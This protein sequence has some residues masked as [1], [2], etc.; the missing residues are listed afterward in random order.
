M[1]PMPDRV[2]ILSDT[3]LGRRRW[4][5]PAAAALRP[6]WQGMTHLVVNGDCA[7]VHHPL[8]RERAA[9]EVLRLHDLCRADG[10]ALVLLS[11]NHDPDLSALRHLRLAD[12]RV[13]VTHGDAIHRAVA[14]WS[15]NAGAMR[16]VREAALAD[17]TTTPRDRLEAVLD[18]SRRAARTEW[19]LLEAES[20]RSSLRGMLL[21]PWSLVQVAWYWHVFPRLASRFA[22][23]HAGNAQVFIFGHTHRRGIWRDA[24]RTI[25]NTGCFGFPGRPFLTVVEGDRVIVHDVAWRRDRYATG[26]EVVSVPLDA[27]SP[28]QPPDAASTRPGNERPSTDERYLAA[29]SSSSSPNPVSIPQPRQR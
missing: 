9:N 17:E 22:D 12:D 1:D 2:A 7:E 24:S 29:T 21:R 5:A 18:A 6:L 10:V 4:C 13:F 14:P 26:A 25:I 28:A 8:H 23:E 15:P 20:A 3:H 19:A 11:G 16:A 27:P